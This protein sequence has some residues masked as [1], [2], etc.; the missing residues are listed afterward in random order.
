MVGETQY[1]WEEHYLAAILETDNTKL[2]EQIGKAHAAIASRQQEL[3]LNH[4]GTPDEQ[5]ALRDALKRLGIL[6][7]ER[8]EESSSGGRKESTDGGNQPVG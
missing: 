7:K 3:A 1:G 4:G 8:I 6:R 5:H 2:P